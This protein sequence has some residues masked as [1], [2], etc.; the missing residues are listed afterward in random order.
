MERPDVA[1]VHDLVVLPGVVHPDQVTARLHSAVITCVSAAPHHGIPLVEPPTEV[2]LA[3][4]PSRTRLRNPGAR[5][6]LVVHREIQGITTASHRAWLA[7]P[8]TTVNRMLL[9]CDEVGAVVAL[10]HVLTRSMVTLDEVHVPGCGPSS[11]RVRRAVART[12]SGARSLLETIA[13]LDLE[14]AGIPVEVAVR[15]EGVGE[16][17]MLVAG[18]IAV[19]T[20][21]K[22][23][24]EE[25]QWRAER[26][27]DL[28][29]AERGFVDLRLNY[30]Q[31]LAGR[32]APAVRRMLEG[33]EQMSAPEREPFTGGVD[34]RWFGDWMRTFG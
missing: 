12:R 13:R 27:R 20:D 34:L 25:L 7:D 10:D 18:K 21:G 17:D 22:G 24:A 32:T 3:V 26:E 14:D 5:T 4:P 16:V 2:H 28:R 29:L 30:G 8:A 11:A 33:L 19:E 31:V 1:V 23:H 9:C 15:I 6:D